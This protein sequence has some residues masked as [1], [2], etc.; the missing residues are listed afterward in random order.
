M[1]GKLY[2]ADTSCDT[3][4]EVVFTAIAAIKKARD[5][6]AH[7]KA[8]PDID[9]EQRLRNHDWTHAYSDDHRVWSAGA[10]NLIRIRELRSQVSP[11]KFQE[12]WEKY[13]PEEYSIPSV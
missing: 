8:N 11:K 12:L 6:E 13:A 2:S 5:E 9:L 10:S 1:D 3:V 7:L 4:S